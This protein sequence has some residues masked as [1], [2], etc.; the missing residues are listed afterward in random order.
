MVRLGYQT[1][2]FSYDTLKKTYTAE[3]NG[4]KTRKRR[5]RNSSRCS[6]DFICS[7]TQNGRTTNFTF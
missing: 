6:S 4:R 7:V 2:S 1:V 3:Y 5:F